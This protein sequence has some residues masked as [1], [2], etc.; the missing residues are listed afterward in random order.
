LS[1]IEQENFILSLYR[2]K[3]LCYREIAIKSNEKFSTDYWDNERI[4]SVI[5]KSRKTSKIIPNKPLNVQ[6]HSMGYKD[7]TQLNQDGSMVSD[8]IIEICEEDLKSP[9]RLLEAHKFDASKWELINC[10]NNLWNAPAGNGLKIVMYQ[11]KITVK[12]KKDFAWSADYIEQLF[13]NI[14]IKDISNIKKEQYE[15]NGKALILPITDLHYALRSYVESSG[16]E[17]DENIAEKIFY[18]VVND[19][20]ERTKHLKFEKIYFTIGSDIINVDNK[21][22]TTTKGTPQVES[23]EVEKAVINVTNMLISTIERLRKISNVEVIHIPSNHDYHVAF[24]IANALRVKYDGCEDVNVDYEWIE[25]KYKV[26]GKTLIGFAHDLRQ[27]N[28][29]DIVNS[30]AR[31]LLGQTENTVYLLAHYHHESVVDKGGTDVR[32]L[33]TVSALSRWGYEQGYGAVRK[34]QS[35]VL[36]SEHGISDIIYTFIEE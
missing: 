10:K 5:R 32:R 7:S 17:Y 8:R 16:N 30:D 15:K 29:N 19:V 6:E 14:K 34:N 13:D 24:G 27:N 11:S 1:K 35:F 3:G 9:E 26:F 25:R 18:Q 22:G 4:R 28:I 21:M 36:D 12:P 31:Q 20:L 2:D 33:P 23:M